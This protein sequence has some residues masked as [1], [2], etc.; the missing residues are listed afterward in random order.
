MQ[1]Q[2]YEDPVIEV[3]SGGVD[4]RLLCSRTAFPPAGHSHNPEVVG[5]VIFARERT[6]AVTLQQRR[7]DEGGVGW[8]LAAL[9]LA[10]SLTE[11]P[12]LY[13]LH[14]GSAQVPEPTE[15]CLEGAVG[16]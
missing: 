8:P 5:I 7:E 9:G 16:L 12:E 14:R 4:S 1:S 2:L 11:L 6:T 10:P 13:S 3:L 15:P